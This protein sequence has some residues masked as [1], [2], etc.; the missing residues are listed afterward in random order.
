MVAV[1]AY[2]DIAVASV[3]QSVVLKQATAA[4]CL[5]RVV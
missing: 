1:A 5:G 4:L 3:V 2:Q